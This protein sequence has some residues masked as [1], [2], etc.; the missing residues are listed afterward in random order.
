MGGFANRSFGE[1]TLGFFFTAQEYFVLEES[2]GAESIEKMLL[3]LADFEIARGA[4]QVLAQVEAAM[5]RRRK[6]QGR[7]PGRRE[8]SGS[9][10]SI[11]KDLGSRGQDGRESRTAEN[12]DWCAR[13]GSILTS[14]EERV[15]DLHILVGLLIGGQ[16]AAL[17]E[18]DELRAG[19]GFV[20]IP[21]GEW[22]PRS[23]RNGR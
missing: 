21:R 9:R 11:D 5:L 20:N 19:D 15:D 17:R 1:G 16:V 23:C 2:G 3:D 4:D 10:R 14:G 12:R 22:A 7:R 6:I 18:H 8:R 13:R